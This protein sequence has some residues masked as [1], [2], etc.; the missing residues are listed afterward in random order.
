MRRRSFLA[1]LV[2]AP[3][4]RSLPWAAIAKVVPPSVG[5]SISEIVAAAIKAREPELRA[6]IIAH[7][8]LLK[9]MKDRGTVVQWKS[10]IDV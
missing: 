6:N 10:G 7:N 5:L 3:L 2:G 1:F 9:R 8:A 4:T